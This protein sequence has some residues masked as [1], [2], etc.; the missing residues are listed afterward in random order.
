VKISGRLDR[1]EM[2]S[3]LEK[4]VEMGK[5]PDKVIIDGPGNSLFRHRRGEEKGYCPE[6]TVKVERKLNGEV[7]RVSVQYHMTEPE[8]LTMNERCELVD[9]VV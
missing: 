7:S 6:R 9:L 8:K 2:E 1:K 4:V 3:V 5:I